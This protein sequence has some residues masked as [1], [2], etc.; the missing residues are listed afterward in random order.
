MT[1]KERETLNKIAHWVFEECDEPIT[2]VE[3]LIWK[4]FPK[5]AWTSEYNDVIKQMENNND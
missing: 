1:D 4:A 3:Y 5:G 2:E